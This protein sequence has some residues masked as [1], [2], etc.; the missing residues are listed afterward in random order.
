VKDTSEYT[1]LELKKDREARKMK[2]WEVA[3]ICGV[4]ESTIERWEKGD[5]VPDPDDVYNFAKAIGMMWI[6]YNWMR[7]HYDSFREWFPELLEASKFDSLIQ[8]VVRVKHEI[9]DLMPLYDRIE[10][11]SLDGRIDDRE[12]WLTYKKELTEAI[13]V[14]KSLLERIS[15]LI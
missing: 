6:W 9:S 3:K 7:S 14:M 11:D 5:A 10:R 4:S 13:A 15:S 8:S 2:R 1:N 12:A